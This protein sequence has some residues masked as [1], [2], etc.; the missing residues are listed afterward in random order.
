MEYYTYIS[1]S[2]VDMIIPQIGPEEQKT[3]SAKIGFDW[4]FFSGSIATERSEE[5]TA[6]GRLKAAEA[7]IL[8][9]QSIGSVEKPESWIEGVLDVNTCSYEEKK[10]LVLWFGRSGTNN[11]C[12]GGSAGH[13]VGNDKMTSL[14]RSISHTHQLLENLQGL[15]KQNLLIATDADLD[16]YLTCGVTR[17][18]DHPWTKLIKDI[19][20]EASGPIQRVKFLAKRLLQEQGPN[21][22]YVLGTPLYVALE[23]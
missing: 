2:K 21:A 6:V 7:H 22:T 11:F 19:S 8:Q 16:D 3:I 5:E 17:S 1:K 20:S 4:V 14:Q 10:G 9:S 18:I 23:D 12:F 15:S 13:L